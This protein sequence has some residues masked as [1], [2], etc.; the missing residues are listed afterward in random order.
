[1]PCYRTVADQAVATR[2]SCCLRGC[3]ARRD[4]WIGGTQSDTAVKSMIWMLQWF[5][6]SVNNKLIIVIVVVKYGQRKGGC[7]RL[8]L[9][10]GAARTLALRKAGGLHVV[11]DSESAGSF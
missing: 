7:R 8:L 5:T 11:Q 10:D 9:C 4:V 2:N 3:S 1:V 6:Q